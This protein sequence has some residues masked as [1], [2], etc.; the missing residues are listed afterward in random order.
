MAVTA[1]E[2][3]F[4]P[5]DRLKALAAEDPPLALE[6][7]TLLAASLEARLAQAESLRG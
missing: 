3:S 4:L 1:C 5:V 6:L 2:F 7:V